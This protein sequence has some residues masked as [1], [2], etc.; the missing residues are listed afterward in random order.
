LLLVDAQFLL[1]F[2]WSSNVVFVI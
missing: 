2:D 1:R